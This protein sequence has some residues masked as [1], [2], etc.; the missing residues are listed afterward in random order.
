MQYTTRVLMMS[1]VA[2]TSVACAMEN[3][4]NSDSDYIEYHDTSQHTPG[5]QPT[6]SKVPNVPV[7]G[8]ENGGG[9]VSSTY[10]ETSEETNLEDVNSNI[11]TNQNVSNINTKSVEPEAV[12]YTAGSDQ[13]SPEEIGMFQRVKNTVNNGYE[14]V[15]NTLNKGY[16]NTT[17]F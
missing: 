17:D 13:P 9:N 15:T 1:L 14:S 8:G 4:D 6:S 3:N 12:Y 11:D 2:L 16:T 7:N 10:T 5:Q